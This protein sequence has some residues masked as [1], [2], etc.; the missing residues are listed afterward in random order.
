MLHIASAE[1]WTEG[2]KLPTD[3]LALDLGAADREAI[4]QALTREED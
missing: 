4:E 1:G 3:K 2:A